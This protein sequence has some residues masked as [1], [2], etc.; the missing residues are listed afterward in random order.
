MFKGLPIQ[1]EKGHAWATPLNLSVYEDEESFRASR[2]ATVKRRDSGTP[3]KVIAS[4]G[5]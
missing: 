2:S 4:A 3:P 5:G 1:Q